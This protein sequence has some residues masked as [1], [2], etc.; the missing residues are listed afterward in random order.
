MMR[1][2]LLFMF[3]PLAAHAQLLMFSVNGAAEAPV[4]STYQVGSVAAGDS[5]DT[6]FRARNTGAGPVNVTNLAISGS[7]FSIIQTPSVP[8]VIAPGSF[9]DIYVHF[10]GITLASYSANFQIVYGSNNI[11]V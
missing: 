4:G 11:S 1:C 6:R 3:A 9:Q 8:F 7:G 2:A 5:R 10:T